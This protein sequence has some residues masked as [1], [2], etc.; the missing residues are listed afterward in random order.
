MRRRGSIVGPLILITLGIIFLMRTALPSFSAFDFF[1]MYWPYL[2]IVWGGLQIVEISFRF[3]RGG[4]LPGNGVSAGGWLL[5][6]FVSLLGL[7]LFETRGPHNWWRHVSFD[8]SM[9]WFGE[10]HDFPIAEQ[11]KTVGRSPLIVIENF[12][13]SVKIS[14]SNDNTVRLSGHKTVR[15]MKDAEAALADR[16]TPVEIVASGGNRVYIRVH[17]ER[18]PGKV[19]V[20]TDLDLTVPKGASFQASGQAGDFDIGNLNGDVRISSDNADVR[21]QNVAG[22]VNVDTRHGSL[23]RCTSIGGDVALKGRSSD[24]E[25]EK[26]AGQVTISGSYSGTITLRELAKPLHVDNYRTTISAAKVN[27]Q[28]TMDRN[29]FSAKDLVGPAQLST[30][31][32]DVEVA[33]FTDALQVSVGKGDI[34]LRPSTATALAQMSI[35][36]GSGNIDLALPDSA[37][38]ELAATTDRG[39]I[40][41][42]YGEPLKLQAAGRGARLL[43]IT[44]VGPNLNLTTDRGTIVVRKTS[45]DENQSEAA[46]QEEHAPQPAPA[47]PSPRLPA[48]PKAPISSLNPDL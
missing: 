26:I 43:G 32:T 8:Q 34:S 37:K 41:N 11:T 38:F 4:A 16:E 28:I 17:Q 42:E 40:E 6:L 5:V 7:G 44:G 30:Q 31:T 35:R 19:R 1:S 33:G 13:G 3:S 36:T 18:L 47:K 29:S 25:L 2:L 20:S 14:G 9:D 12:R 15:S 39:E 23:V 24:V 10:A 46:N 21:L 45:Q 27:G 48:L 22:N